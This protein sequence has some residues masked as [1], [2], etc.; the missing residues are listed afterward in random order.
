MLFFLSL[1]DAPEPMAGIFLFS[2]PI[3]YVWKPVWGILVYSLLYVDDEPAL[4]DI[5]KIFLERSKDF[6]VDTKLSAQEGLDALKLH[7]YDAIVSNYHMP[8]MN[9]IQFLQAIREKHGD[10]PFVLFTGKGNEK[11]VIEAINSRADFYLQ[12]DGEPKSQF[13]EISNKIHYAVTRKCAEEA[14]RESEEKFRSLIE[15]SPD[16]I[17]EIDLSGKIRYISPM[18]TTIMGYTPEELV[19]KPVTDLIPEQGDAFIMQELA[20]YISSEGSITPLEVSALH[21]DGRNLLFEIRPSRVAGADGTLLGFRG[22]ARDITERKKIEEVLQESEL[23]FREVFDNANDGMFLVERAR[24]GPGKYRLVNNKAVQMLGYSKEEILEMSPRDIVPE[25]IAKKIMPEVVKKLVRDGHATFESENR[26]KDGVILPLEVSIRAFRYKGKDVD[27]S[28]IR[29]ITERKRDMEALRQANRK[30][31][32][33][34]G[35]N[36]HDI[37]NQSHGAERFCRIV[38]RKKFRSIP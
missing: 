33:L 8:G 30:L 2:E 27:L 20:R 25:N 17:W 4:L 16:I 35:I 34:S 10:I 28:I 12:K 13:A 36:R 21:R 3:S 6:F 11:V 15:T 19:G 5:A 18:V 38:P 26:R 1:E 29:D 37:N 22:V 32:L 31:N 23:L 9:G 7:P 14:L 24:D